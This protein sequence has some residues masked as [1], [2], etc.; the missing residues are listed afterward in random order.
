MNSLILS[1]LKKGSSIF[2]FLALFSCEEYEDI[3]GY[4]EFLI[5]ENRHSADETPVDEMHSHELIYDVIFDSSAIYSI[6]E[7]DQADINKL[8]GFADCNDFHHDN[9]ARFGWRWYENELQILAYI[10]ANEQRLTQKLGSVEL[11]KPYRY[12]IYLNDNS[13]QFYIDGVTPEVVEMTRG[14]TCDKGFYYIL[15]PYF[16][17]NIEAPHD[18]SIFMRRIYK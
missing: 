2:L 14:S 8:F 13:Y 12:I 18:I 16:G 11:G 10:Y 7:A 4:K 17:G 9:S 3:V 1:W 15:F 6:N 5:K